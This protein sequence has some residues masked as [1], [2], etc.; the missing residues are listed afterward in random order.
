MKKTTLLG[1]L[2]VGSTL[3]YL[4]LK[5]RE[6][7]DSGLDGVDIT[8]NPQKL[9]DGALAMTSMNPIAKEGIRNLT[10][11]ALSKYYEYED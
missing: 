1:L 8:V 3:A 6:D 5:K 4:W 9:I 7:N 2:A 11:R 10:S